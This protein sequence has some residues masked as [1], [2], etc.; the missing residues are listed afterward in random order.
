MVL[1]KGGILAVGTN[2]GICGADAETMGSDMEISM[3][4]TLTLMGKLGA[5]TEML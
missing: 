1:R 3:G 4:W 2:V 5:H